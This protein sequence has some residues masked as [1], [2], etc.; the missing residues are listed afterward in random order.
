M[1][2]PLKNHPTPRGQELISNDESFSFAVFPFGNLFCF[3]C[4]FDFTKAFYAF[5]IN[6]GEGGTEFDE[7]ILG[8]SG[9]LSFL[10]KGDLPTAPPKGESPK[11]HPCAKGT[12]AA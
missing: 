4:N 7:V 11:K 3:S 12:E 2:T 1:S 5:R 8:V 6:A 10:R 9:G